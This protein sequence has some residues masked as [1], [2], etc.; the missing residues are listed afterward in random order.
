MFRTIATLVMCALCLRGQATLREAAAQRSL[1]IGAA[2][3]ADEFGIANR[4]NEAAYATTL[5]DHFNLLEPEN[6]LKWNPIRPSLMSY[7]FGPPDQLV[8]FARD[9]QM[10]VRGHT[11]VWHQGLP[12]WLV[13]YARTATPADMSN[14]LRDHIRTML[15]HFKG[16]IFAW[17][18]VNEA[19]SDSAPAS[20]TQLRNSIWYNQPGIGLTGTG[21]IEQAFRWAREADPDVLLFY[22]D[23][24]IES[25]TPKF[26]AVLNML[27]DFVARGVPI[28]GVGLQ[29][30]INTGNYP[31]SPGLTR[32][33]QEITALGLQVHIT[34][35]DVRVP[36]NGN[37]ASDADLDAQARQYERVVSICLQNPGC[38]VVQTWGFT[39]KYSWIPGFYTGFGSALLFDASYQP[40]K[41]VAAMIN[42]MNTVPATLSA[43]SIVNAASFKGGPVAPGELVTIF[44]A[45]HGPG[46]LV[47]AKLD[48]DVLSSNLGGTRVLFDGVPAPVV[49]SMAGQT[50][51]IVPFEVSGKSQTV[52]QYEYNG[53]VSNTVTL[54]VVAAAPGIFAADASGRGPG[55]ILNADGSLNSASKPA[56]PGS[57]IVVYATGGGMP[58][59]GAK[60]GAI[61][62]AVGQQAAAV[63]ATIGDVS[64]TVLYA[65]PAPGLVN[66]VLQVNLQVPEGVGSGAQPLVISAGG[67]S[68]QPG[69]TASIQ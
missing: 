20:G 66:G 64:A 39:D 62:Q 34:E 55:L 67:A 4:L 50:S 46:S 35:M 27:K 36:V 16:Q 59:E 49:Y 25:F 45:N 31:D 56:A 68:S 51:A 1:L 48:G 13:Q 18:V 42:A 33:I 37:R 38:T 17:D 15:A 52:V 22:N 8:A 12:N 60:T 65:G 3:N 5:G 7:N 14:L 30:H 23:Y 63:A 11:F 57:V 24:S 44:Q 28:D 61:A 53:V 19:V 32:V 69:I 9:H 43:S 26:Q 41:A 29:M 40:K 10:K 58:V 6:A 47:G 2:A 54:P 21:Y